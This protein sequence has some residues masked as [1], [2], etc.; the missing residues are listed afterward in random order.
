M[1]KHKT[2]KQ[3][4][5]FSEVMS[6]CWID[7][8]I[9]PKGNTTRRTERLHYQRTNIQTTWK[10]IWTNDGQIS[11]TLP[12]LLYFSSSQNQFAKQQANMLLLRP[13]T[14]KDTTRQK[15][16]LAQ[17]LFDF[18]MPQTCFGGSRKQQWN[19]WWWWI[20][21]PKTFTNQHV[22]TTHVKQASKQTNK[23]PTHQTYKQSSTSTQSE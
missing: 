20:L 6:E 9:V 1:L 13:A 10:H 7:S 14:I 16:K 4:L 17:L 2:K 23:R 19:Q 18:L 3:S 12:S 15:K 21:E 5:W 11:D 22:Q 8:D